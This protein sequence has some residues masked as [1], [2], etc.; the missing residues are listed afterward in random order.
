MLQINDTATRYSVQRGS[1]GMDVLGNVVAVNSE[2]TLNIFKE[3]ERCN[4]FNGTDKTIFPPVQKKKSVVWTYSNDACR[5]FPLRFKYMKKHRHL[6]LAY[7][8]ALF[9]DPLVKTN[10][11]L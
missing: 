2:K 3:D 10:R 6:K 11:V 5:S 1:H 8:S 9:N 4:V 7:K